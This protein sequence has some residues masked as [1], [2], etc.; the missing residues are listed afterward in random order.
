MFRL[1]VRSVRSVRYALS[2]LSSVG[3]GMSFN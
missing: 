1:T 3:F 2:L